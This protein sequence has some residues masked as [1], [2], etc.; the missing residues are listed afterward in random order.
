MGR[1][2]TGEEGKSREEE[3]QSEKERG[4]GR[5]EGKQPPLWGGAY[6]AVAR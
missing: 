6:L 3:K 1:E 5:G 4:R 2:G